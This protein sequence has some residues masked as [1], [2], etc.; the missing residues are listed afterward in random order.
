MEMVPREHTDADLNYQLIDEYPAYGS[1]QYRIMQIM[2]DG[3][4]RYSEVRSILLEMD[5]SEMIIYPNPTTEHL[6][7]SIKGEEGHKGG[8]TTNRVSCFCC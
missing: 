2:E 8:R 3:S 5:L 6:F 1:N 7:V 4:H